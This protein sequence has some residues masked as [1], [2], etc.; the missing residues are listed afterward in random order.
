LAVRDDLIAGI[1]GVLAAAAGVGY[2]EP[3]ATNDIYENYV[4]TLCLE[5]AR[6]QQ[7]TVSFQTVQGDPA[8]TLIFRT[9]PGAIYSTTHAYTH[10]VLAF[11][12]CPELE[13]HVGIR[14]TGKSQVLHECDVA[15]IFQSEAQL[16]RAERVH[17]RVS[18]VLVAAECKFYTSDI[19][20]HLG[21]GFLG[22]TTDIHKR[23]RYFVTNRGSA[24]VTKLIAHH[25]SE[26]E[27]NVLPNSNEANA[28]LHS[29]SRAFRNYKAGY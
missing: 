24:S 7:A 22:L 25:Q 3:S 15:V 10:A 28:L 5:A 29:F 20:L 19:Q 26:W 14:V 2:Q 12:R 21:R 4:W 18:K 27:C 23:Q 16:C 6:Q 9:S 11:D 8:S 13:L 17:P 1:E